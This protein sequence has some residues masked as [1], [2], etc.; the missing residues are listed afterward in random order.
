LLAFSD[1]DLG[2]SDDI[3]YKPENSDET[4]WECL[5]LLWFSFH[6]NHK[7]KWL[8]FNI[9]LKFSLTENSSMSPVI[10]HWRR[11]H[12]QAFESH[13]QYWEA[14]ERG[15]SAILIQITANF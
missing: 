3:L 2:N 1:P 15:I 10:L 5:I 7:E 13:Y 6:E 12:S 8:T 14:V 11:T 4:L 9:F